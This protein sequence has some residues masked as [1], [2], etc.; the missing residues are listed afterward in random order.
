MTVETLFSL[1]ALMLFLSLVHATI[2]KRCRHCED[3]PMV[4]FLTFTLIS[5]ITILA[6]MI[7]MPLLAAL[8]V[9]S[10]I[11]LTAYYAIDDSASPDAPTR[12]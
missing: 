1:L 4:V 5:L 9:A 2:Y 10:L 11:W 8:G 7:D 12:R 6:L 3:L